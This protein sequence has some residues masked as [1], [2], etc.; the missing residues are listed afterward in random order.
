M[1]DDWDTG[2]IVYARWLE[3]SKVVV[4]AMMAGIFYGNSLFEDDWDILM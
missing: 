3:Y 4:Y 2:V 1:Q